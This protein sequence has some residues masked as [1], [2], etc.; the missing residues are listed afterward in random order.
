MTSIIK[1]A[2]VL[3][4]AL[5]LSACAEISPRQSLVP[6]AR[7]AALIPPPPEP[8]AASA[9]LAR[10]YATVQ[11]EQ[12]TQGLLRTDGGGP[13]TPFTADDLA[14]DFERIVFYEEYTREGG[15]TRRGGAAQRL[16][17]WSAP[18]R[19][20]TEFGPSVPE[21]V[22]KLDS[23]RIADYAERLGK[24]TRH[25]VGVTRGSANFNVLVT[26]EDDS[27]FVQQ[28]LREII[29]TVS[30][31]DLDF[32]GHLPRS[33]YCLVVAVA[34]TGSPHDYARAVA[35]IRAEQPDLMRLACIHEEIAQGLGLPNDSPDA[36]P[37][38]FNDDDEFALLT[39]HDEML[40]MMLYDPRLKQGMTAEEARPIT[41]IMARELMGVE[42]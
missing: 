34:G 38:I 31:S 33:F 35:V 14:E 21:E 1:A 32:F 27:A 6:Q 28:R 12:L 4:A 22:R 15:Q 37:S 5:S 10:Y 8:S 11:R 2:A 24:L 16:S 19:I 30:Q 13:D 25:P 23:S 20:S 40:L 3:A 41:R 17:R 36:R 42:L 26:G 7:P 29:P 18:V 9:S 39:N